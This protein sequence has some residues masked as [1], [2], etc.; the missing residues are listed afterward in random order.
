M[1]GF[2]LSCYNFQYAY[3][4]FLVYYIFVLT[5]NFAMSH[6]PDDMSGAFRVQPYW[7]YD[8]KS[9]T[10]SFLLSLHKIE[11]QLQLFTSF[12]C[13]LKVVYT[14]H[15]APV[16]LKNGLTNKTYELTRHSEQNRTFEKDQFTVSGRLHNYNSDHILQNSLHKYGS[17]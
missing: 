17:S 11:L 6:E 4:I 12:K 15:I 3:E 5:A 2:M 9:F 16:H 1:F 7:G 13:Q 14:S 8:L 10:L